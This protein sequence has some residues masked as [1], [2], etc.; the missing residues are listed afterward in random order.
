MNPGLTPET[1]ALNAKPEG[2]EIRAAGDKAAWLAMRQ[3]DVT[4]SVAGAMFGIHPYTT[5]FSL[6][7]EK[8]GRYRPEVIDTP[9][10]I[11]DG[12]TIVYPPAARGHLFERTSIEAVRALRPDW[13][14]SYPVGRYWTKPASR[15]GCTPDALAYDPA[16]PGGFGIIQIKTTN[17]FTFR[18]EWKEDG[19]VNPPLWIALQAMVEA[20]LTGASWA[21]VAVMVSEF[22]TRLSVF[23]I[24][25]K[26]GAWSNLE[27]R[28]AEFWA[29]VATGETPEPDF[30]R[31]AAVIAKV[32]AIADDEDVLDLTTN[33]RAAEIVRQRAELKA[34][35][36]AGGDAEAARKPLDGELI[37]LLG[38]HKSARLPGGAII[39]APTI[40][41]KEG[42][43]RAS[44]HRRITIKDF[45]GAP[46][47]RNTT[48]PE[49]F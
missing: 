35:E 6:W 5:G 24:P 21:S 33:N 43:V 30:M 23:D 42:V 17:P 7:A 29:Q 34:V 19:M 46:A 39:T 2:V 38:N 47:A 25:I 4:A 12:E 16:R 13:T 8:T 22:D 40:N 11:D 44:S 32:F 45:G 1:M 3:N 49:R 41:R 26:R 48:T 31:D 27:A 10:I 9:T 37:F 14:I 20:V 36:K 18:K 28:V 15:I